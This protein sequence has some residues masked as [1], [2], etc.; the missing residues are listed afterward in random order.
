[1]AY[2]RDAHEQKRKSLLSQWQKSERWK[3]VHLFEP[4]DAKEQSNGG[5]SVNRTASNSSSSHPNANDHDASEFAEVIVLKATPY[6]GC[7]NVLGSACLNVS[8]KIMSKIFQQ[9][10]LFEFV[11]VN[12]GLGIV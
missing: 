7:E 6:V 9:S 1:V 10:P 5:S 3:R 2:V 11:Q 8:N 4:T 12:S